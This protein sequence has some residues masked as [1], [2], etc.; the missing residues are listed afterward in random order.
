MA[1]ILLIHSNELEYWLHK[2]TKFAEE[3]AENKKHA[4]LKPCLVCFIALQQED[5]QNI[6]GTVDS[7]CD[8]ILKVSNELNEK[9]I[10][11][12]PYVHLLFGKK[13]CD[14]NSAL[15]ILKLLEEKLKEKLEVLRVPFGFYKE[16]KLHCKGHRHPLSELSREVVAK[17]TTQA[18]EKEKELTS[19]WYI[20]EPNGK[21]NK[22][23]FKGEKLVG[24]NFSKYKNLESFAK[25]EMK[26]SRKAE[27]QPMHVKLMKQL[28]LADYE[29]GSDPGNLRYPPNGKLIKNL[30]AE[31]LRKELLAYGAYEIESPEIFDTKHPALKHYLERFPARQYIVNSPNKILFMR[32]AACFGQFLMLSNLN[33]SY[34]FMP[35]RV[36]EL[37]K[38]CYRVEQR[39]ELSG[40][41]RLRAFT[42]PDCHAFCKNISQAK[43]EF[44]LRFKLCKELQRNI[45]IKEKHLE[46]AIRVVKSFYEENKELILQ[47][48]KEWGKPALLEIWPE[49]FFYFILKYEFNFVDSLQK[50]AALTTD[51][52]DVENAK[53]YGIKFTDK[54]N[55]QKYPIILHCSPSGA[56]E[57]VMYALIEQ[58]I[59]DNKKH[60]LLPLWLS[61]VQIRLCPINENY[62]SYCKEIA[63][64]LRKENIRVDIDDRNESINKKIRD[65][66]HEWI[67]LIAVIG[68][69][70][71]ESKKIAIRFRETQKIE[72]LPL[73]RIISYIKEKIK[74]K[75]SQLLPY[76]FL[77]KK[78]NF[79]AK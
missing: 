3:V 43:E 52:I 70:E 62:I 19:E 34:K 11:I 49:Q 6:E 22:I 68:K 64:S 15:K 21:L 78:P 31:M 45:G 77:S 39:G 37:A 28:E 67:P 56:L 59:L 8:E 30:L 69:K 73:E 9:N 71:L 5:A 74:D 4:T 16:F 40:L 65:A 54:D 38:Y 17:T 33:L 35:L 72:N 51:Q 18:L 14:A 10:A 26:K 61:P 47:L 20:I 57:R 25:Y 41:R 55:K 27:K 13:P 23:Q 76:I 2:K 36:Y 58:A 7:L 42:M 1:N 75:P 53:R 66:E 24:F 32:F 46:L 60:P 50:A 44:M 63:E 12:Y 48:V 29:E 79:V